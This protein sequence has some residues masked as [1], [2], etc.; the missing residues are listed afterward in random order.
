MTGWRPIAVG[1][2]CYEPLCHSVVKINLREG[3]LVYSDDVRRILKQN[4]ED[5]STVFMSSTRT[6]ESTYGS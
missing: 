4:M 3:T 2:K 5:L 6:D 1:E